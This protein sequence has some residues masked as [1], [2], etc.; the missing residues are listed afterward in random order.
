MPPSNAPGPFCGLWRWDEASTPASTLD[1]RLTV[2][3]VAKPAQDMRFD[4][5]VIG[6]KTI[7]VMRAAGATCLAI[8]AGRTLIFDRD[9]V[10]ELAA[11]G[12][13]AIIAV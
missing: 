12:G 1:R 6:P 9:T 4:V 13:I 7:A 11:A 5:P 8:E 10:Q 3:K 2:V